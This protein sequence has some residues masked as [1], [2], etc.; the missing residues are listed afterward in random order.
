MTTLRL[1]K[2]LD[3]DYVDELIDENIIFHQHSDGEL[4]YTSAWRRDQVNRHTGAVR[5]MISLEDDEW[6][7][8]DADGYVKRNPSNWWELKEGRETFDEYPYE[9]GQIPLQADRVSRL[10]HSE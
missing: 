9:F 2:P 6:E 10:G 7:D 1:P 5:D 4:V 3:A 8:G